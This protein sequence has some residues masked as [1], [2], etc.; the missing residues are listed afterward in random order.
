MYNTLNCKYYETLFNSL[1]YNNLFNFITL[2][3]RHYYVI[4]ISHMLNDMKCN[5]N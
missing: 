2:Y 5:K 1:T 3:T 4:T